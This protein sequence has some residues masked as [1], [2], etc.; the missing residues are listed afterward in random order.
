MRKNVLIKK[1]R[2]SLKKYAK[3]EQYQNKHK[4]L[5]SNFFPIRINCKNVF[6]MLVNAQKKVLD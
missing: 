3:M 1:K 2:V 5:L 4:I 6:K